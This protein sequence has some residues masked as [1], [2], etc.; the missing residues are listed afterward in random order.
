MNN[1]GIWLMSMCLLPSQLISMR[2]PPINTA[3]ELK[4]LA[5][6]VY[7]AGYEAKLKEYK[8][9]D[10]MVITDSVPLLL[11][12]DQVPDGANAHVETIRDFNGDVY[13]KLVMQIMQ[14]HR[15]QE[16]GQTSVLDE[17]KANL[18]QS[19]QQLI[20]NNEEEFE[21]LKK[22][23]AIWANV[24]VVEAMCTGAFTIVDL[25]LGFLLLVSMNRW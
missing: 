3:G 15:A 20:R 7:P 6:S 8:V 2:K 23:R 22:N 14:E 16:H 1:Y 25:V 13:D 17:A 12:S 5:L 24:V 4:V 19:L 21:A 9:I 18:Y 10:A 11:Y